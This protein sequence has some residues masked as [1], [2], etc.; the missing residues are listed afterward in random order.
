MHY[1]RTGRFYTRLK[2]LLSWEGGNEKQK[3]AGKIRLNSFSCRR[4]YIETTARICYDVLLP[5]VLLLA[6]GAAVE[7][8]RVWVEKGGRCGSN[9]RSV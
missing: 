9:D 3:T 8:T 1:I 6:V 7:K 2:L 5:K 4:G